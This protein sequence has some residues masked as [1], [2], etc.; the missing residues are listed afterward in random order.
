[1]KTPYAVIA[2]LLLQAPYVMAAEYGE[3][4]ISPRIGKSTL[5]IKS[6]LLADHKAVDID[7]LASGVTLGYV[8]PIGFMAEAGYV[9]QGNWDWFGATDE[10]QLS[11]YSLA[12]GYQIETPRGFRII[13]KV[14]RVRWDLYSKQDTLSNFTTIGRRED[15]DTIRSYDDFW[16][17]TLQKKVSVHRF[18]RDLQRHSLRLGQRALHRLHCDIWL[19][20]TQ[21]YRVQLVSV[22]HGRPAQAGRLEFYMRG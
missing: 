4:Q 21:L 13:P 7:T 8:T 10:Y 6:D 14:G 16:E 1:M 9:K 15:Q 2:L 19:I 3:L 20:A 11:E 22:V 12:V 5:N 17:V 18:G